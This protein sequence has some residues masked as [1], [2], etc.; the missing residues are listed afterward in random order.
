MSG[1]PRFVVITGRPGVG[2]TTI[3]SRVVERLRSGGCRVVGFVCPEVRVGGRR[4]GF[5]IRSLDGGMEAWL[6]HV[7]LCSG[8]R[9]G[10]YRLCSEAA[11]VAE[12]VAGLFSEAD[13]IAIDEIGPMELRMPAVRNVILKAI[14][15][16]KPGLFVVHRR[17]SDP[18]IYPVLR[19]E[20]VWFWVTLENRDALPDRVYTEVARIAPCIKG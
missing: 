3:F 15:A 13:V 17:L 14:G 2:K 10:R 16:G 8:G 4:V 6:A 9:V 5:R 12:Y 18:E 7:S 1:G 20:G 11:R 19:R